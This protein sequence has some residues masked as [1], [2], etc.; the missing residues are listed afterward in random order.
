MTQASYTQQGVGGIARG[1]EG[2]AASRGRWPGSLVPERGGGSLPLRR[3]CIARV[4]VL[5]ERVGRAVRRVRRA[6]RRRAASTRWLAA[7][8]VVLG[9]TGGALGAVH[10]AQEERALSLADAF[11]DQS[12]GGLKRNRAL[13]LR[14]LFHDVFQSRGANG[15]VDLSDP[16]NFGLGDVLGVTD[17][18]NDINALHAQLVSQFGADAMSRADLWSLVATAAAAT[19]GDGMPAPFSLAQAGARPLYYGRVDLADCADEAASMGGQLPELP[20]ARLGFA[21]LDAKLGMQGPEGLG[22]ARDEF[23][24]L[25]AG[26]HS[27]GGSAMQNSGYM[28]VWVDSTMAEAANLSAGANDNRL[29]RDYLRILAA[30]PMHQVG[31]DSG[32]FQWAPLGSEAGTRSLFMLNTDMALLFDVQLGEDGEELT[33]CAQNSSACDPSPTYESVQAF[34]ADDGTA[35]A[36]AFRRAFLKLSTFG[37]DGLRPA[38]TS[39]PTQQPSLAPTSRPSAKPS[40][41]PTSKPSAAPTGK[42][43]RLPS[44]A[45]TSKPSAAPTGKPTRLPSSAPTAKPSKAPTSPTTKAPTAAPTSKA[46]TPLPT[47]AQP[48]TGRPTLAADAS[49]IAVCQAPKRVT[50]ATGCADKAAARLCAFNYEVAPGLL[51]D[52]GLPANTCVPKTLMQDAAVINEGAYRRCV[53]RAVRGNAAKCRKTRGCFWNGSALSPDTPLRANLPLQCLPFWMM[54]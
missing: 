54:G 1:A 10:L 37:Y 2:L 3:V 35:F 32:K 30:V 17:A 4:V 38:E 51:V 20:S 19:V 11:L 24:A 40:A 27:F 13:S 5:G 22:M 36:D 42:P 41:S 29:E 50:S 14:L 23:T 16:E 34:L 28:G 33:S 52:A 9:C 8:A 43:T 21:E 47:T 44:R 31:L 49:A 39:S 6:M 53:A 7:C 48:T 18:G 26:A 25:I 45:P 12:V 15:C 46:P